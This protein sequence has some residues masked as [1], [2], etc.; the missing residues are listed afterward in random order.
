[1][2]QLKGLSPNPGTAHVT[3]KDWRCADLSL[4]GGGWPV[5]YTEPDGDSAIRL[6][7]ASHALHR[8]AV[9]LGEFDGVVYMQ[10]ERLGRLQ[11]GAVGRETAPSATPAAMQA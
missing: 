10:R 9:T 3:N 1:M 7:D 5:S 6:I 4:G 11:T 8:V 2:R